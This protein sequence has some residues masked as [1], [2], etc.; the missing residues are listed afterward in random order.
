MNT[1]DRLVGSVGMRA[2]VNFETSWEFKLRPG[3]K[4]PYM[5][6]SL[7]VCCPAD[8]IADP[9]CSARSEC[10]YSDSAPATA[11]PERRKRRGCALG[12]PLRRM[13]GDHGQARAG[14]HPG[15]FPRIAALCGVGPPRNLPR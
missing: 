12:A 15:T 4:F 1:L 10:R 5:S 2:R 3:V 9:S 11:L 13:D 7:R 14:L 6:A 8:A